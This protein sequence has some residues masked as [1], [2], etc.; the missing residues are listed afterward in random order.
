M[1]VFSLSKSAPPLDDDD[2]L[3]VSGHHHRRQSSVDQKVDA[4]L[5]AS[6]AQLRAA[7]PPFTQ[8]IL[9]HQS[10]PVAVKSASP[11][12]VARDNDDGDASGLASAQLRQSAESELVLA[13]QK[14]REVLRNNVR[15]LQAEQQ[16]L[17]TQHVA[18]RELLQERVLSLEYDLQQQQRRRETAGTGAAPAAVDV[19]PRS[20]LQ[21][22][23][24]QFE[25]LL[26][27]CR[28]YEERLAEWEAWKGKAE[29]I[30]QDL[31]LRLKEE[32]K[33]RRKLDQYLQEHGIKSAARPSSAPAGESAAAVPSNQ[34]SIN[35]HHL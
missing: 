1:S 2:T 11:T 29:S 27:K 14:E 33:I 13:L 22:L 23:Q 31:A 32:Q 8:S 3:H 20:E 5:S 4:L 18:E 28:A 15:R 24:V 16:A 19:V 10:S 34:L 26:N 6:P 35:V 21:T 12:L 30:T 7:S 25:T 9:L 17:L